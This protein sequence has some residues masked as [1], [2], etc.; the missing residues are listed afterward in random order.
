MAVGSIGS[1]FCVTIDATPDAA[2]TLTHS[3]TVGRA[4]KVL[5]IEV[6]F[7]TVAA[8]TLTVQS[9]ATGSA[10]FTNM[11]G[12]A[13]NIEINNVALVAQASASGSGAMI[14][15]PA[16]GDTLTSESGKLTISTSSACAYVARFIC[17]AETPAALTVTSA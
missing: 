17:T 8:G 3:V 15:A 1:T 4:C 13:M 6:V 14:L 12:G 5:L 9:D 7:T 16:A 10:G 11:L 2:G